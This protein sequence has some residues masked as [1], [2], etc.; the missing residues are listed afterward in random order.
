L[1]ESQAKALSGIYRRKETCIVLNEREKEKLDAESV[2]QL[3]KI[4]VQNYTSSDLT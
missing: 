3:F 2:K 1:D 4:L